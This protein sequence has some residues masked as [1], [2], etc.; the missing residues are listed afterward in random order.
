MKRS[1]KKHDPTHEALRAIYHG[2]PNLRSFEKRKPRRR[3][4]LVLVTAFLV[5]IGLATL[6]GILFFNRS[7]RFES[8]TVAATLEGPQ[9]ATSGDELTWMVRLNNGGSVDLTQA[10]L[11]LRYPSGFSFV[12]AKPSPTNEFQNNWTVGSLKAGD[13]KTIML[14]G[15]LVGEVGTTQRLEATMSYQPANF[16]SDF[17]AESSLDIRITQSVLD[18][19]VEGPTQ[20]TSGQRVKHTLTMKNSSDAPIEQVRLELTLPSQLHDVKSEPNPTDGHRIWDLGSL[21]PD[22]ETS[23]TVQATL[24]GSPKEQVELRV[25]A[26]ILGETSGFSLQRERTILILLLEPNLQVGL[27]INGPT[28][29]PAVNPDA[30]I[31]AKVNYE[32]TSESEFSDLRIILTFAGQDSDGAAVDLVVKDKVVSS[33]ASAKAD[34]TNELRWTKEE[35]GALERLL[36]GSKGVVEISLPLKKN[37]RSL[38][39]GRNLSLA[40][41]AKISA[42]N[43]GNTG[44]TTE[45]KTETMVVKISTE[46]RFAVEGRYYNDEGTAVGKGPLPPQVGAET[47]YQIG[48]FI[49]NTLN[50]VRDA[51]LK[52]VLPAGVSF[53]RADTSAGNAITFDPTTR[54]V[55]WRIE[56]ID[57]GVGQTLPTLEGLF[58]VSVTPKESDVGNILLLLEPSVLT[59]T[60]AFSGADLSLKGDRVM[61]DLTF[62]PLAKGKGTVIPAP[63]EPTNANST[64]S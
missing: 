34:A 57:A 45:R 20:A 44:A 36:P 12:S 54:E 61:T 10:E 35:I 2:Q 26:G 24:S 62:D 6:F 4:F 22:Q 18:L 64:N 51:L 40:L 38:G 25:S 42:A 39:S 19:T 59:A 13:E 53:H 17:V 41:R 58:T 8:T 52:A 60:D 32:N 37:L 48:W 5:L 21:D 47:Q 43:I 3:R 7:A 29:N 30:T 23:V 28:K 56:K 49:T 1:R 33:P 31:K 11:G 55:R 14:V 27:S 63:S 9:Q 50:G 15:R 46:I 16:S